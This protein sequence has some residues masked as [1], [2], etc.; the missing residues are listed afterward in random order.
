MVEADN[1][2][3]PRRRS[4]RLGGG[5]Q[6]LAVLIV[7]ILLALA[8][9]PNSRPGPLTYLVAIGI[10][11]YAYVKAAR[12][13]FGRKGS[14]G[15][16]ATLVAGA[17]WFG[18]ALFQADQRFDELVA[19][20]DQ[21]DQITIQRFNILPWGVVD[22]ISFKNSVDND[23]VHEVVR[24]PEFA[25]VTHVYLESANVTDRGLEALDSLS[26][27]EYAY[28]DS[29]EFSLEAIETF[30]NRH[31]ECSVIVPTVSQHPMRQD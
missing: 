23:I 3:S 9:S 7:F 11:I 13:M 21:Y 25:G 27:L 22:Q 31:P 17:V 4:Y 6:W 18:V 19:R 26:R 12:Y 8:S 10:A 1:S 2:N 28:L 14:W 16:L 5:K 29:P 24:M 15:A 20:M 30:Q